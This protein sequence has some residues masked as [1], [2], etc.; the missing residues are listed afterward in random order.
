MR[1]LNENLR[2]Q[3]K[4]ITGFAKKATECFE[5]GQGT[6]INILAGIKDKHA[7][8]EDIV[9]QQAEVE[10]CL[11]SLQSIN[12]WIEEEL[13]LD[14]QQNLLRH[15]RPAEQ[16]GLSLHEELLRVKLD[17][18]EQQQKNLK[19]ERE[20]FEKQNLRD[21]AELDKEKAKLV[22][23]KT[24]NLKTENSRTDS[25][26]KSKSGK[27]RARQ[28][29]QKQTRTH[30]HKT[31][32]RKI[33]K[34]TP[35]TSDESQLGASSDDNCMDHGT[36]VYDTAKEGYCSR[37]KHRSYQQRPRVKLV[38]LP[39]YDSKNKMFYGEWKIMFM[40][41]YG[42][43]AELS[44]MTK[45]I[46]LKASID[47]EA[48]DLLAGLTLSKENYQLAWKIL[49]RNYLEKVRPKEE[50]NVK[51][52]ST[53]IHQTNFTI[54]K[55]D[56]SKLTAIVYDMKNRGI[57]VDSALIYMAIINKLPSEIGEKLAVKT[58]RR[59]FDGDFDTF[60]DWVDTII[61]SKLFSRFIPS[62]IVQR[63]RALE[64]G[65]G[66][67]DFVLSDHEAT[68]VEQKYEK[69]TA[70]RGYGKEDDPLSGSGH[71]L[72]SNSSAETTENATTPLFTMQSLTKPTDRAPAPQKLERPS[73]IRLGRNAL[74]RL[75]AG[76]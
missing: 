5:N 14:Q 9:R 41:C 47:G 27:S 65:K 20:E 16:H 74:Q 34:S 10:E 70:S 2:S 51:F 52:L 31:N 28:I 49:D 33:I 32:K 57:D 23:L 39:K 19:K 55:A 29:D 69:E 59:D 44:T 56:I 17:A 53:E 30:E 45:F 8:A 73:L 67:K 1:I 15:A 58:Q 50:L 64:N 18:V 26:H 40:E 7:L 72:Q 42:K 76:A 61:N 36:S 75:A 68:V 12:E 71:E 43:N 11:D 35:F 6:L 46:Q 62:I 54:M 48:R 60:I 63:K 3:K 24:R 66:V 22:Q 37:T 13:Q 25:E 4:R 38:E 21:K